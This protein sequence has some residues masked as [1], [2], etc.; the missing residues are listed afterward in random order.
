M[1]YYQCLPLHARNAAGIGVNDDVWLYVSLAAI[2][3]AFLG[4]AAGT[5]I[6]HNYQR[7]VLE[8]FEIG[9]AD[10]LDQKYLPREI[11]TTTFDTGSSGGQNVKM[12]FPR[13]GWLESA[14][15]SE[16]SNYSTGVRGSVLT[17]STTGKFTFEFRGVPITEVYP[18]FAVHNDELYCPSAPTDVA[19]GS[20]HN[21]DASI[22]GYDWWKPDPR[23]L[24][25]TGASLINLSTENRGDT[26]YLVPNDVAASKTI[27]VLT[28][29]FLSNIGLTAGA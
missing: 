26:L 8:M 14:L 2:N 15:F 23:G 19:P 17:S 3:D 10:P 4:L 12:V 27:R 24:A 22:W 5:T 21:L 18:K 25:G 11:A 7:L 6:T 20:T 13:D 16:F 1:A 29:K 9:E 28:S